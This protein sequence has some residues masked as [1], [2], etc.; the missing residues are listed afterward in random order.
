MIIS[1]LIVTLFF[2]LLIGYIIG[3][4][5]K[6]IADQVYVILHFLRN[7]KPNFQSLKKLPKQA[8]SLKKILPK[9]RK[10]FWRLFTSTR[11]KVN[12]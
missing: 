11:K 12:P 5:N 8:A 10:L 9:K 4:F 7:L 6:K 1:L 2:G 3:L